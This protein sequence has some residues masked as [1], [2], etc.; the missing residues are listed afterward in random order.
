MVPL[1]KYR[2]LNE[3]IQNHETLKAGDKVYAAHMK[4][5]LALFHIGK[6]PLEKG[7]KKYTAI[8]KIAAIEW[9][10]GFIKECGIIFVMK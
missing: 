5:T 6:E 2:D 3:V 8:W 1:C 4:K 9:K 10:C 7:L